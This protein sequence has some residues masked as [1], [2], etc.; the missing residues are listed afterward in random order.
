MDDYYLPWFTSICS[1]LAIFVVTL[2][3]LHFSFVWM[4]KRSSIWWKK[5]DYVWLSFALIG[6]LFSVEQSRSIIARNNAE[7]ALSRAGFAHSLVRSVLEL[8]TSEA[9]CRTFIHAEHSPPIK[10]MQRTQREYDAQCAWF[11]ELAASMR[12]FEMHAAEPINLSAL[13]GPKP[14]GGEEFA[15]VRLMENV[16]I[17]NET[18]EKAKMF[19]DQ[20]EVSWLQQLLQ[21][22]GPIFLAVALALRLTKVSGEIQIERERQRN[23]RVT[24]GPGSVAPVS[25]PVE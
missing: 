3:V 1:V 25:P 5:V 13:A 4:R 10:D 9:V 22:L 21:F 20:A 15:Y 6:I 17:Y 12:E 24:R 16:D 2:L 7:L 14:D 8:G 11:R 23:E 19:S 18:L